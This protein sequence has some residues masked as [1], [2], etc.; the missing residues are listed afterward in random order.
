MRIERNS[1]RNSVSRG[2]SAKGSAGSGAVFRPETSSPTKAT[3]MSVPMQAASGIDAILALQGV[4]T[5]EQR[6]RRA[7]NYGKTL[8]D[9]LEE[10]KADLLVGNVGEGRLNKL[11]VQIGR[12]R[13]QA[14]PDLE[15]LID[16]IELRARVEV[17]KLGRFVARI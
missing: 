17:A 1:T 2:K 12:A 9:T 10:M 7:V 3:S 13:E 16:D 4:D 5:R 14:D 11:M 8:L 6:Q 15:A